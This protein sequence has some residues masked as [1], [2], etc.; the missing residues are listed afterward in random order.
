MG[1]IALIQ[2]YIALEKKHK[3]WQ[4]FSWTES[5]LLPLDD[6]DSKILRKLGVVGEEGGVGWDS[7]AIISLTLSAQILTSGIR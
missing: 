2:Y 1:D 6:N 3:D 5:S 4:E 7:A